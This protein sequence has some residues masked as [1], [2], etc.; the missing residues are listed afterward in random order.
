M[1]FLLPWNFALY[2]FMEVWFS[3]FPIPVHVRWDY[4][5]WNLDFP[6]S[7]F[8]MDKIPLVSRPTILFVK[9]VLIVTSLVWGVI[10]LIRANTCPTLLLF[11]EDKLLC[12]LSL[13]KRVL[14]LSFYPWWEEHLPYLSFTMPVSDLC[15][16]REKDKNCKVNSDGITPER[17][18]IFMP[19]YI[20]RTHFFPLEKNA[21]K[22]FIKLYK[23][24]FFK[25]Q[26]KLA[27][28]IK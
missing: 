28:T 27:K 8:S 26:K 23:F 25:S 10:L 11:A 13:S 16:K 18:G 4:V 9:Y 5:S 24:K 3:W 1:E 12:L 6:G 2:K 22:N 19:F 15:G 21:I 20:W 17:I 7:I 14:S